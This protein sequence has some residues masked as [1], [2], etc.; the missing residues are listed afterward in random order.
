MYKNLFAGSGNSD[1]RTIL[2]DGV[3]VELP[4][5]HNSLGAIRCYLEMLALERQRTLGALSVDGEP[6]NLAMPLQNAGT[7][8]RIEAETIALEET[9][10]R[11]LKKAV[12]QADHVRECIE[13]ALTLVLIN[14]APAAREIWWNL[15][16]VLKEPVLTL[17]LLPKDIYGNG[18]RASL[19]QLHKWQLEQVAA[20]IRDVNEA[21]RGEDPIPLSDALEKR[22][23]PWVQNLEELIN[24]WYE[25]ALAGSRLGAPMVS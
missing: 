14:N 24:L 18:S 6:V 25:T 16:A 23:L 8:C 9:S 4:H 1:E 21:C 7:F 5:G 17:S 3:P 20:I 22:V 15:A 13:T 19:T 11:L 12:Q 10:L 2:L